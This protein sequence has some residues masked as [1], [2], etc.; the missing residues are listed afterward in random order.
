[1]AQVIRIMVA[2]M[3]DEK[4]EIVEYLLS[5]GKMPVKFRSLLSIIVSNKLCEK[6]CRWCE[7]NDILEAKIPAVYGSGHVVET[8]KSA[9]KLEMSKKLS[10]NRD[11]IFLNQSIYFRFGPID[12]VFLGTSVS[13]NNATQAIKLALDYKGKL[14]YEAFSIVDD[15]EHISNSKAKQILGFDPEESKYS[16]DQIH[17]LLDERTR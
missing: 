17:S 8:G 2:V 13:I 12:K 1:M 6:S 5:D 15:L 14:W 16:K 7:M 4:N 3:P 11:F 9:W 10:V